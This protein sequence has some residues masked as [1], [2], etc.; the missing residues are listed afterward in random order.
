MSSPR[1][2]LALRLIACLAAAWA[3][4]AGCSSSPWTNLAFNPLLPIESAAPAAHSPE[5]ALRL[6]EWSYNRRDVAHHRTLFSD[7]FRFIFGVL[8]PAGFAFR[9]TSWTRD[10]ELDYFEHLVSGDS[11]LAAATSLSL[12]FDRNFRLTAD[13]YRPGAA[14]VL[15]RTSVALHVV[16]RGR[17]NYDIEGYANFFLVRGDSASIPTDLL[18][19]G[20]G[21]DPN[22]WFIDRWEDD[23]FDAGAHALPATQ[24]TWGSLKAAYR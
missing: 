1:R 2:L 15:I 8:D 10:D 11:A 20:I 16:A 22:R 6:L 9:D 4:S 18:A 14:H 12:A 17:P 7:D 13:P 19:Q 5:G 23:T 3:A 24:L 21:H